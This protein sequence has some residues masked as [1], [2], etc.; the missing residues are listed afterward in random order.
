MV[1]FSV[2]SSK[3]FRRSGVVLEL[4]PLRGEKKVKPRPETT[5]LVLFREFFSGFGLAS[6]P[7][8]SRNTPGRFML[9]KPG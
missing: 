5:I 8:G 1:T 7:R 4:V 2:L 6:H 3:K 9:Q